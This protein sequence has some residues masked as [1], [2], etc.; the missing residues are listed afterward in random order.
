MG[1]LLHE[2]F[3][4]KSVIGCLMK[5]HKEYNLNVGLVIVGRKLGN[6]STSYLEEIKSYTGK[7]DLSQCIFACLKNLSETEK[8]CLFNKV[9]VFIY[10]FP[11]K[12]RRMSVVVPPI[13]LLESMSAGLCVVAG[14]LPY[15]SDLIKNNENGTLINETTN[16]KVFA[17]GVWSAIMNKRKISQNARSTIE[18]N[19]S[20]QYVSKLYENFLSRVGV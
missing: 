3:D 19:F 17:E 2:R 1:P 6:E 11:R 13:A 5:L 20:V 16:E 8:V 7:N 14:G 12:P 4:F 10:P 15:L 18:N 9:H